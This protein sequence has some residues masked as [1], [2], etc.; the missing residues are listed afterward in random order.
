MKKCINLFTLIFLLLSNLIFSQ[1]INYFKELYPLKFKIGNDFNKEFN[2]FPEYGQNNF[3]IGFWWG[4]D[5]R[6]ADN[7]RG[8]MIQ[9]IIGPNLGDGI[10][11]FIVPLN[12]SMNYNVLH[13][14]KM[15]IPG[16]EILPRLAHAI[17][18]KARLTIDPN[19]VKNFNPINDSSH[20]IFGF[21]F[22]HPGLL[23]GGF[24]S[25]EDN[26]THQLNNSQNYLVKRLSLKKNGSY[27]NSIILKKPWINDQITRM[28][29]KVKLN[30]RLLPNDKNNGTN[31]PSDPYS[32]ETYDKDGNKVY[33]NNDDQTCEGNLWFVTINLRRTE[34]V[35]NLDVETP[36][37]TIKV[38]YYKFSNGDEDEQP[39]N[40]DHGG[41]I[42]FVDFM[43]HDLNHNQF[44]AIFDEGRI[45]LFSYTSKTEHD[46]NW[47][48][49]DIRSLITDYS[50]VTPNENDPWTN[51]ID[52]NS[53]RP[54]GKYEYF[55]P[56]NPIT[57]FIITYGMLKEIEGANIDINEDINISAFFY[58][59][60]LND[61]MNMN[62]YPRYEVGGDD[63]TSEG[64]EFQKLGLDVIYHGNCNIAIDL[65]RI[66]DVQA[67]S[68]LK[69]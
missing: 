42:K 50:A 62:P 3:I 55:K 60:G 68:V 13:E 64:A 48:E 28:K 46:Y 57:E 51:Y 26:T 1:T 43:N 15:L 35:T 25:D 6:I 32:T 23:Q 49:G 5:L 24:F 4:A 11:D 39:V 56:Q 27:V 30:G 47:S 67:H 7:L 33:P 9:Q 22:I 65:I 53:R 54:R 20:S 8:N 44:E 10:F 18:F 66:E 59:D 29:T 17:E 58:C 61:P 45:G 69:G 37:L 63:N 19:N 2:A 14:K 12:N 21:R 52:Q 31:I 38:P 34:N 40:E 36:V 16:F 41:Y